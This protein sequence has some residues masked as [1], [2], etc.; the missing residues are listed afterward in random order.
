[1]SEKAKSVAEAVISRRQFL[2]IF[3]ERCPRCLQSV[4]DFLSF[5]FFECDL[6]S[7]VSRPSHLF[8]KISILML[9]DRD[10]LLLSL[11]PDC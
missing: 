11:C 1:M 9:F 10:L 5:L 6:L 2:V 7:K 8:S 4:L 3:V